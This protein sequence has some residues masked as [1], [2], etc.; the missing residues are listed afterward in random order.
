MYCTEEIFSLF[1]VLLL[2]GNGQ[3]LKSCHLS[4]QSKNHLAPFL[5]IKMTF[6]EDV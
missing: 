3:I 4:P 5:Y 6:K 2:A 1:S